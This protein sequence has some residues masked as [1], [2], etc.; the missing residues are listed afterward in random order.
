M[1]TVP[2]PT[3]AADPTIPLP[4]SSGHHHAAHGS[5]DSHDHHDH[6][7]FLAHHFESAEQQFDSGKLGMWLFLVTEIMFFSGLFCAYAVYRS[8][9][10]EIFVY[11]HKFL[12]TNLGAINTVVLLVSS[13]T[14]ALAVRAAQLGQRSALI[15]NLVLTL[16]CAGGFLGIKYVEYSHKWHSGLLWARDFHPHLEHGDGAH[17]S[18]HAD[19]HAAGGHEQPDPALAPRNAGIFFSIYF[20]LTGLH[21]IH[22]LAGMGAI[23]WI[24]VRSIRGDFTPE[25]YG[26]VDFVGLYWHLVDLVWIY[27]FPLLYLIH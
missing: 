26:P 27:L 2:L 8:A 13:L 20:C 18:E 17:G 1:S 6:P 21:G 10:P 19:S 16:A 12:D 4:V 7:K 3:T 14:M 9:H 23:I 25:Y 15:I 24:L 11:A 5:G 22:I